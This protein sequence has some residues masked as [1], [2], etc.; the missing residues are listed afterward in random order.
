M[1]TTIQISDSVKEILTRM[2]IFE[3][4]TYNEVIENMIEDQLDIN[5]KTKREL[6]ERKE[7]KD[8]ISLDSVEREFGL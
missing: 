4:E 3:K 1:A 7:S 6:E 8:F 2:R 5:A